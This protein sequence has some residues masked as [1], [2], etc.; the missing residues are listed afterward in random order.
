MGKYTLGACRG[1]DQPNANAGLKYY[2]DRN[3]QKRCDDSAACTGFVLPVTQ[4]NWCETYTSKGAV[5]DKRPQFL[6][7]MKDAMAAPTPKPTVA[8]DDECAT[9]D[10]ETCRRQNECLWE[11]KQCLSAKVDGKIESLD[12]FVEYCNVLVEEMGAEDA[13]PMCAGKYKKDKCKLPK[14]AKKIKCKKLLDLDLCQMVGCDV[15]KGKKCDGKA[16]NIKN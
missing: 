1:G 16:K 4:A 8:P 5:G 9:L 3:C 6:C 15:K 10:K 13:C 12:A 11:S 2:G 14:K 7:Y